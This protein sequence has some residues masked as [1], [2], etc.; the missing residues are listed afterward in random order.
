MEGREQGQYN[1]QQALLRGVSVLVNP[2]IH[3]VRTKLK[4]VLKLTDVTD[5]SL[6]CVGLTDITETSLFCI[7][8]YRYYRYISALY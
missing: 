6:L 7:G 5:T 1:I 2:S 8:V 4:K 3:K